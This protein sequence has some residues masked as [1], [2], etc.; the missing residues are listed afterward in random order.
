[1]TSKG[2]KISPFTPAATRRALP[3]AARLLFVHR[4]VLSTKIGETQRKPFLCDNV[5]SVG[6]VVGTMFRY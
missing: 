6:A 4:P 1:M 5:T 2:K 3:D